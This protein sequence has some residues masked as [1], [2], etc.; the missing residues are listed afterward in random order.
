MNKLNRRALLVGAS[1]LAI[2]ACVPPGTP[3]FPR[4]EIGEDIVWVKLLENH[5]HP[6]C[7]CAITEWWDFQSHIF[8]E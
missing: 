2:S 4:N 5:L 7:R 3:P 6:N 8:Y 1:A